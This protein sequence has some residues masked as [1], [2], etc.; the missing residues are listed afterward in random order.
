MYAFLSNRSACEALRFLGDAASTAPRW[1]SEARRLPQRGD[2]ISSQRAYAAYAKAVG[3]VS[4]GVVSTPVDLLV[5]SAS[6]R[7]R[8]RRARLHVWVHDIPPHALIRLSDSLFVSTPEFVLLQMAG[9]H[10]KH[11]PLI[12]SFA[13][14]L[15]AA[16]AAQDMANLERPL[17]YDNPFAWELKAR[18]VEMILVTME[19]CGSYRLAV[20]DKPTAYRLDPPMTRKRALALLDHVPKL[21]GRKRVRTALDLAMERSASPMETALALMLTLP[22]D[23]GGYG[24]PQPLL[25]EPLGIPD[26]EVLWTGG[27][28]VTPDMLWKDSSLVIE[29]DSDEF[30]AQQGRRKATQDASRS[31]VLAAL[32]HTVLRVTTG[33]IR[34]PGELDRL[35]RQV[36]HRIGC[37]VPEANEVLEIRRGRLHALLTHP[38]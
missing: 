33:T 13:R 22:E 27:P 15:R 19:F 17:P 29:Y 3:I 1:P 32:G 7:S 6:Q 30:H 4:H 2:C 26:H 24:L 36:A 21:Y 9:H 37:A 10:P 5:P 20:A 31:N 28:F 14:D 34:A 11:Q 16:Q 38:Q 18:L 23:F 8:G 12:D 25:N 35:A